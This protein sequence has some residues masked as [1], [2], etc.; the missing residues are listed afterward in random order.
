MQIVDRDPINKRIKVHYKGYG[1]EGDEWKDCKETRPVMK[2]QP[3]PKL[4]PVSLPDRYTSFTD[5]LARKIKH[6]LFITKRKDPEIIISLDVDEDVFSKFVGNV[7]HTKSRIRGKEIHSIAD[8][9][10]LNGVL[11]DC[12]EHRIENEEGDFSYVVKGTVTF[13]L[14]KIKPTLEY[15]RVGG[16]LMQCWIMQHSHF[17]FNFVRKEGTQH[18]YESGIWKT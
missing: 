10:F 7:N 15:K 2:M 3:L 4:Y 13:H 16:I 17:V 14:N 8:N 18:Q 11:G 9:D 1:S 6:S 5:T 12:W